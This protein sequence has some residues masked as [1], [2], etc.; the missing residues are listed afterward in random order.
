MPQ[1]DTTTATAAAKPVP[2]ATPA[3]VF[4]LTV[5]QFAQRHSLT[6]TAPEALAGFVHVEK[7]EGRHKGD[8][9]SYADRFSAFLNKPV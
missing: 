6:V 2:G 4:E 3:P 5:E 9:Q 1:T 8:P 7:T